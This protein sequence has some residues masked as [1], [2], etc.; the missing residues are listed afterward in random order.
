MKRILPFLL[1]LPILTL[2]LIGCKDDK[3][4]TAS[5]EKSSVTSKRIVSVNKSDNINVKVQESENDIALLKA[6]VSAKRVADS[7]KL[8]AS[9]VKK[10]E[11]TKPK[12]KVAPKSTKKKNKEVAKPVKKT[13]PNPV[14]SIPKVYLPKIEFDEVSHDFG[15][16]TEGDVVKYNFTFT[17]TGKTNLSIEKATATCGC[18][19]PSFPFI[20]IKPGETGY[21]GVAYHSVNKDGVQKP[22]IT[23]FSNAKR[24]EITL[25]LTGKVNPK[26]QEEKEEKVDSIQLESMQQD[27]TKN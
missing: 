24:K 27:T 18:T 8:A 26:P 9:L 20:D 21:I 19:K 17:N 6:E 1:L 2:C 16:I 10:V 11:K 22:E 5:V 3:V 23:V 4:D 14:R 12:P 15:E 7:L 25:Y 13:K